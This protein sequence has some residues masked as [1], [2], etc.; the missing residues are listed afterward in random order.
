M[1]AASQQLVAERSRAGCGRRCRN[2]SPTWTTSR[3]AGPG[4]TGRRGPVLAGGAAAASRGAR[5]AGRRS[6][7]TADRTVHP[8]PAGPLVEQVAVGGGD[9]AEQVE[10]VVLVEHAEEVA[11]QVA[12]PGPRTPVRGQAALR[13][14]RPTAGLARNAATA[15][16]RPRHVADERV[17]FVADLVGLGGAFAAGGRAAPRR[18]IRGRSRPGRSCVGPVVGMRRD[19]L[20]AMDRRRWTR[21][22]RVRSDA[23]TP[24]SRRSPSARRSTRRAAGGGRRRDLPAERLGRH[25]GGE[26]DRLLVDL[27]QAP[28][29][30][31]SIS[32]RARS[33]SACGVLA[34]ASPSAALSASA[35]LPGLVEH[36]PRS[37]PA[38]SANSLSGASASGSS[39]S[40][41]V[42]LGLVPAPRIV[43]S[44]FSSPSVIFGQRTCWRTKTSR[45]N[46][47]SV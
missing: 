32:R 28:S 44:R 10:P 26:F 37:C 36:R 29:L 15:G 7:A 23:V 22:L 18:S 21:S 30:A 41:R 8:H 19:L 6:A 4:S 38:A 24:C 40:S 47:I 14:C 2:P 20:V 39:A 12:E 42:L 3:R 35:S 45:P 33:R 25:Q 34:P 27:L 11:E 43:A 46:T 31:A 1:A 16:S 13:F 5:S 9:S 17:Q